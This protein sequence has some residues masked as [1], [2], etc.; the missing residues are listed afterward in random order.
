MKVD[1][2]NSDSFLPVDEVNIRP[3]RLDISKWTTLQLDGGYCSHSKA[4][5][6]NQI[7]VLPDSSWGDN[8]RPFKTEWQLDK[9]DAN[10]NPER[11]PAIAK[12]LFYQSRPPLY[13]EILGNFLVCSSQLEIFDT[14][15][16]LLFFRLDS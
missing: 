4:R 9:K 16:I 6:K 2:R 3:Y 13:H 10:G 14:V 7:K 12:I 8:S 15:I 1:D 11:V 5:T